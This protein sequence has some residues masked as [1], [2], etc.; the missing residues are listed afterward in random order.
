MATCK[1]CLHCEACTTML[2]AMGY[3]VDGDGL[4]ADQRCNTFASNTEYQE[5]LSV[6]AK[7][8]VENTAL[9]EKYQRL[10][11]NADILDAALR[12]YQQKYG[13]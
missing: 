7:L 4:D 13:E 3:T 1:D 11:E 6:A 9:K 8:A 5:L 2:E 12:E 10:L